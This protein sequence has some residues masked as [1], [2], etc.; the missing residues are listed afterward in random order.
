VVYLPI[1]SAEKGI[2]SLLA[3][4]GVKFISVHASHVPLIEIFDVGGFKV[5]VEDHVGV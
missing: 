2:E 4:F 5:V 3:I 1:L